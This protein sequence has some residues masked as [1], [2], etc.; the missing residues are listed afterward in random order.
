MSQEVK[1]Y[2]ATGLS[3]N[4]YA[5]LDFHQNEVILKSDFDRVT[6]ELEECKAKLK[7]AIDALEEIITHVGAHHDGLDGRFVETKS[8][9]RAL[10]A[11]EALKQLEE[12]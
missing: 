10:N 9:V 5:L 11:L 2:T 1:V 7:I 6:K 12:K 8:T 4:G 3:H